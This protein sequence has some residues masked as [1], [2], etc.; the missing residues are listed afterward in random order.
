MLLLPDQKDPFVSR[1]M[2]RPSGCAGITRA[3]LAIVREV[4]TAAATAGPIN[5]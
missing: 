1:N 4:A 2:I 3:P 5:P